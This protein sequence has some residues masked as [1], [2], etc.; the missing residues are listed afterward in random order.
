M[1]H[2]HQFRKIFIL[3]QSYKKLAIKQLSEV[4][5][6]QEGKLINNFNFFITAVFEETLFCIKGQFLKL[7]IE[8]KN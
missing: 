2:L 3:Q 1:N 4:F 5:R 8:Q 6:T 7:N